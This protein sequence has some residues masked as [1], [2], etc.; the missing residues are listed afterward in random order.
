MGAGVE[1][2]R[3]SVPTAQF[4][5]NYEMALKIKVYLKQQQQHYI[6]SGVTP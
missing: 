3:N 6:H 1:V 5:C 4:F 2:Y